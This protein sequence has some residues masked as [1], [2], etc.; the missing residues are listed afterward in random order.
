MRCN[1]EERPSW[2]TK[3][4]TEEVEIYPTDGLL[5]NSLRPSGGGGWD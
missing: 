1:W 2:K 5:N 3:I 4:V